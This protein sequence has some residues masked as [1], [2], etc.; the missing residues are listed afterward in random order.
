MSKYDPLRHYLA[1]KRGPSVTMTFDEI[2]DLVGGLP[3][4]AFQYREWWAN[5]ETHV[6]A[7]AWMEAGW[8]V[9]SVNRPDHTITFLTSPPSSRTQSEPDS[10]FPAELAELIQ[11]LEGGPPIMSLSRGNPNWVV[12]YDAESIFV[13]TEASR[14]KGLGAQPVPIGWV[15]ESFITLNGHGFLERDSLSSKAAKRSAF[16]FA[17]LAQLPSVTVEHQPIRLTLNNL[18]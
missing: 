15:V 11:R 17:F 9:Q 12:G 13:E 3:N 10:G 18:D 1:I 7:I 8:Y 4:S 14:R 16:I 2:A 5:D 6:Q